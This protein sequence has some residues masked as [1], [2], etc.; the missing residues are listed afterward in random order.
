MKHAICMGNPVDGFYFVGPFESHDHA[1]EYMGGEKSTEN[2]WIVQMQEPA[3][4]DD[5][6]KEHQS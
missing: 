4:A 6:T 3:P 5:Q 2:M 1:L